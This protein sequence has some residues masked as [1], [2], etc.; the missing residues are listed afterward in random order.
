M[1]EQGLHRIADGGARH[2]GIG[3]NIA[4]HAEVVGEHEAIEAQPV[5]DLGLP[6]RPVILGE[7]AGIAGS[8]ELFGLSRYITV[9]ICAVTSWNLPPPRLRNRCGGS[10]YDTRFCTRSISFSMCP[11]ETKM[12]G[13]PSLS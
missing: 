9:P 11:S 3:R 6:D 10:A 2:F 13:H 1:D 7:F 12:S 8:L 4:G 5:A